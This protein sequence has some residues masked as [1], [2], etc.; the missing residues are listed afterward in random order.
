MVWIRGLLR[1]ASRQDALMNLG[2][3]NGEIGD[4]SALAFLGAGLVTNMT[5]LLCPFR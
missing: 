3:C 4:D 2:Q 5:R 1:S